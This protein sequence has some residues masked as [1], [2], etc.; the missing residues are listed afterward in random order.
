MPVAK[1]SSGKQYTPVPAGVHQG[2]CVAIYDIGTQV[3]KD[4]NHKAARK[5]WFTWELPH[6]TVEVDGEQ[7]P[8]YLSE[9]FTLSMHKKGKL[10]P[11]LQSWRG[12]PFTA[13]ELKGFDLAG[14]IGRNCQLNVTHTPSIKDPSKVFANVSAVI[15]LPKGMPPVA[16]KTKTTVY[17]IPEAGPIVIPKDMPEWIANQIKESV[18][19]KERMGNS[20]AIPDE[21]G[22]ADDKPF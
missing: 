6:E 2:I 21:T 15:P 16:P 19:Y 5:V 17:D 13:D 18:E 7:K 4:P 1:A 11:M 22:E 12:T 10:L 8:R 3:P 20:V 9:K 14:L